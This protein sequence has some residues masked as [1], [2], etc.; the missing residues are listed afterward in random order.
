MSHIEDLV[1]C[2]GKHTAD[3]HTLP[4]ASEQVIKD[5]KGIDFSTIVAFKVGQRATVRHQDDLFGDL[6]STVIA[7]L[8]EFPQIQCLFHQ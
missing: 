3:S 5:I 2:L 8:V 4:Q 7:R 1:Q 6:D